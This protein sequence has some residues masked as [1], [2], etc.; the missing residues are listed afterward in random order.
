MHDLPKVLLTGMEGFTGKHLCRELDANGYKC[1]GLK[2]DLLDKEKIQQ[3]IF[4][5][6]PDYVIH[7]AGI[8]FA[9]EKNISKI[10]DVNVIGSLNILDALMMLKTIPKKV[11]ISSSA[12]V[13]GNTNEACLDENMPLYPVSHYGCSKLS[14]EF[15]ASNYTNKLS[16]I[17][18]RPFNYTGV[19]HDKKFLIPKIVKSYQEGK[20]EIKLGNLDISREFNDVRDICTIYRNLLDSSL[21]SGILNLCSGRTNSIMEIIDAMDI[22][23]GYKMKI[24][25]DLKFVRNNEI[26]ELSGNKNKLE[27]VVPLHFNYGIRDTLKW[28]FLNY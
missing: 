25:T 1:F 2:S 28:M 24:K 17:I 16:I 7:L 4:S 3:E 22:I 11:I 26:K 5:I 27:K 12:A 15:M 20:K 21:S 10:Y 6:N 19:G 13:Y 9:A 23:A 18:T 14:M 8:S